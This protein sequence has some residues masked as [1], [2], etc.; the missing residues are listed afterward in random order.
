M[1]GIP[2][3][4]VTIWMSGTAYWPG[5][6]DGALDSLFHR[7]ELRTRVQGA[8]DFIVHQ[9]LSLNAMVGWLAR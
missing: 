6:F 7:S 5:I 9:D 8:I 3:H 1:Y 4:G 2:S